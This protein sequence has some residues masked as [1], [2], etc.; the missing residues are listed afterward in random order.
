M[1]GFNKYV[2]KRP[3]LAVVVLK[4]YINNKIKKSVVWDRISYL[5]SKRAMFND[6]NM[7]VSGLIKS[8]QLVPVAKQYLSA[9]T[10]A[11]LTAKLTG[12]GTSNGPAVMSPQRAKRG[13]HFPL[14]ND[15]HSWI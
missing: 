11:Y 2:I 8:R 4:S 12:K 13:H 6:I 1:L 14:M 7:T 3:G 10:I 9:V 15:T 5:V